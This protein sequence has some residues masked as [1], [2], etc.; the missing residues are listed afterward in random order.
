MDRQAILRELKKVLKPYTA[1]KEML[2]AVNEQTNLLKDL[3]INSSHL[4]DIIIDAEEKY[5]IEFDPESI[6]KMIIE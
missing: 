3:T 2:D 1:S 6:E 5:Q 4:V